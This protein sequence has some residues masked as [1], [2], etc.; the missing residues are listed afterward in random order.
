[1]DSSG[2]QEKKK[3]PH[4]TA[5]IVIDVQNGFDDRVWGRRNNP[6]AEKNI[7]RLLRAWRNAGMPVVYVKH[8]SDDPESPLRPGQEGNE[9]KKIV[10][11]LRDETIIRKKVNN[12]FI[13]TD[14]ETY[15]RRIGCQGIVLVGLTTDHCISST[16]RMGADLGFEVSI[17]SDA[18][19]TFDRKGYDGKRYDA[20]TV[21]RIELAI[22]NEKFARIL[23]TEILLNLV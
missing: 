14:L 19:A 12:A 13:G 9:I 6:G 15:L 17:V 4:N 18:T 2:Q 7:A 22:L 3:I 8:M 10:Q 1:M 5:L 16:A 11:P 21:H 23:D 20:E